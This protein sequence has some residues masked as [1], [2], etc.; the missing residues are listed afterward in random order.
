MEDI[1]VM[2]A[3][4]LDKFKCLDRHCPN[5]CYLN[6]EIFI[7]NIKY[8][9]YKKLE[10]DGIRFEDVVGIL[11][12]NRTSEKY[13]KVRIR[14]WIDISLEQYLRAIN[15]EL[16]FDTL[17]D[18]YKFSPIFISQVNNNLEEIGNLCCP[19]I[20]SLLLLN[21]N[22]IVQIESSITDESKSLIY[23]VIDTEQFVLSS[24]K[25]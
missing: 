1:N 19:K 13:A 16:G 11:G 7:D 8:N 9:S 22:P 14:K 4:Y 2:K 25:I 5:P 21:E 20:T 10:I 12:K 24:N 15:L 18:E 17:P 6:R 3:D 23:K